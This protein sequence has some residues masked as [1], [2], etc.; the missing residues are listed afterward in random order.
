MR[1]LEMDETASR[2]KEA[3]LLLAKQKR[4][5]QIENEAGTNG[6]SQ[7]RR[8]HAGAPKRGHVRAFRM[9]IPKLVYVLKW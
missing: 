4:I 7:C 2:L 3:K 5:T 6:G 8:N 9:Q 1:Q